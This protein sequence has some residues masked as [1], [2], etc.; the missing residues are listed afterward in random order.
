MY[1]EIKEARFRSRLNR[2]IILC[3]IDGEAKLAHLPNPGRMWELLFPETLLYLVPVAGKA[4]KTEYKVIGIERDGVPIMLDTH[5]SNRVAEMLISRQQIPQLAGWQVLKREVPF[6]H[7]RFDL[8]LGRG[9]ERFILEI[10]SC[11]LF[12]KRVAMFP[13]AVTERGRKHMEELARLS[14]Q[15]Y[16]VGVLFLIHWQRAEYFLPDYHTD[17]EFGKTFFRLQ[18]RVQ[19]MAAALRWGRDFSVPDRVEPVAIPWKLIGRELN[20]SGCYIFIV[21]LP[22]EQ[23]IDIGSKGSM[24]FKKGYYLYVGSAKNSLSKRLERHRRK[25][26]RF[27][28]HIDYLRTFCEPHEAIAIRTTADLEHELAGAV[29]AIADWQIPGFGCSDC[30]CPSHLFGMQEDPL[31]SSRFIKLLQYFRMDRLEAE[32]AEEHEEYSEDN[33]RQK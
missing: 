12:G 27:H 22:E 9:E 21:R 23:A 7:S 24:V 6:G 32:L 13:D 11:T 17:L 26:K 33:L 28:W 16:R 5:H 18:N 15:G 29:S 2:F 8:L 10:K 30:S 14:C 19:F 31:H 4:R 3:E 20:D 1:S 25:R